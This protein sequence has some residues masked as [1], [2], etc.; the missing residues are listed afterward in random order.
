MQAR[1]IFYD[2]SVKGARMFAISWSLGKF[3]ISGSAAAW[4]IWE[5]WNAWD[6]S[7]KSGLAAI[8]DGL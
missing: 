8:F 4:E 1:F 7:R 3:V 6:G 5:A 2:E